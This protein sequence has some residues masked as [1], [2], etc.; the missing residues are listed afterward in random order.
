MIDATLQNLQAKAFQEIESA[1]RQHDQDSVAASHL[2]SLIRS[3]I[4]RYDTAVQ[5]RAL[6]HGGALAKLAS[7]RW[8]RL[9]QTQFAYLSTRRGAPRIEH[10][11]NSHSYLQEHTEW[12]EVVEADLLENLINLEAV[13]FAAC[14]E[15]EVKVY[16]RGWEIQPSGN[17]NHVRVGCTYCVAYI[18]ANGKV[19]KEPSTRVPPRVYNLNDPNDR[20]SWWTSDAP[21]CNKAVARTENKGCTVVEYP[22]KSALKGS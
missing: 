8:R 10:A 4:S 17:A 19:D 13:M 2:V 7:T 12:Y 14:G 21:D 18:F 6:Y 5:S 3:S 22:I 20:P 11:T 16:W 15:D 9:Q 1:L